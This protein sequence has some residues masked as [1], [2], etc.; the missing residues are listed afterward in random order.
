MSEQ[1]Q[2][3]EARSGTLDASLLSAGSLSGAKMVK[4]RAVSERDIAA[5]RHLEKPVSL[6]VAALFTGIFLAVSYPVYQLVG[7]ARGTGAS[8]TLSDLGIVIGWGLALGV[9]I[10]ATF[11]SIRRQTRL[12][13]TLDAMRARPHMPAAPKTEAVKPTVKKRKRFGLKSKK[14]K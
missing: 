5:L 10:T 2:Q 1:S 12:L 6:A 9:A 4:Y 14:K 13:D 8:M 7:A 11:A 3:S